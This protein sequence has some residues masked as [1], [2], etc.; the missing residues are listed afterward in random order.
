MVETEDIALIG[1]VVAI[2]LVIVNSRR[3]GE[4]SGNAPQG[5]TGAGWN[6]LTGGPVLPKVKTGGPVIPQVTIPTPTMPTPG[7]GQIVEGPTYEFTPPS[8]SDQWINPASGG[9]WWQGPDPANLGGGGDDAVTYSS[10]KGE[11]LAGLSRH[12]RYTD[13]LVTEGMGEGA[14]AR[15][16]RWS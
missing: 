4:T 5:V 8:E 1:A 7:D 16:E 15:H 11:R 9:A 14:A 10:T 6:L 2:A 3:S 13:K 12:Q